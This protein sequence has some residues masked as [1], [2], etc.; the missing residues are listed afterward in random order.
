MTLILPVWICS[1][2]FEF[3]IW[4]FIVFVLILPFLGRDLLVFGI[5]ISQKFRCNCQFWEFSLLEVGFGGLRAFG[6]LI[7]ISAW[8]ALEFAN[9]AILTV[10]WICAIWVDFGI[11]G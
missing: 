4:A 2:G 6:V 10:C 11:S 9:F 7:L 5:G 1:A 8:S 3:C